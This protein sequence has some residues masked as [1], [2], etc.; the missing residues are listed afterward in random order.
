MVLDSISLI[1]GPNLLLS[2]L[3]QHIKTGLKTCDQGTGVSFHQQQLL[4][5]AGGTGGVIR[6]G[7]WQGLYCLGNIILLGVHCLQQ[8]V[9]Y[10]C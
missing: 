2:E 5:V 9:H 6:L 7:H 3:L 1:R 8:S 10:S 4:I